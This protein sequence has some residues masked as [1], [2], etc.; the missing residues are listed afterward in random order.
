MYSA[1]GFFCS[2]SCLWDL[3]MLL[4]VIEDYLY[5]LLWITLLFIYALY[6]LSSF[7]FVGI[8]NNVS[9]IV[10][11]IY[12]HLGKHSSIWYVSKRGITSL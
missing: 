3:P 7:Q 5:S 11:H 4:H 9:V 10:S 8:I 1:S 2:T 12:Q 6:S